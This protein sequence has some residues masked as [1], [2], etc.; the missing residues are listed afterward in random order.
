MTKEKRE[1]EPYFTWRDELFG[2]NLG[3]MT[4][5]IIMVVA[6]V[7]VIYLLIGAALGFPE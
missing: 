6:A 1:G 5:Q 2:Y 3:A 7:G 4:L